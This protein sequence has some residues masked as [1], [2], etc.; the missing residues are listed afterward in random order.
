MKAIIVMRNVSVINQC[1]DMRIMDYEKRF[2]EFRVW[3][4]FM[5]YNL[6][7]EHTHSKEYY[8]SKQLYIE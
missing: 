2:Q 3:I 7:L 6:F 5:N 1:I 4:K 8:R